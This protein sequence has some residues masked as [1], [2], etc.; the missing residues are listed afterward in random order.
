MA[1]GSLLS[2]H[3]KPELQAGTIIGD[4]LALLAVVCIGAT[5]GFKADESLGWRFAVMGHETQRC[6][7]VRKVP[8]RRAQYRC[9]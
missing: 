4:R 6:R 9:R 2:S 7:F 8:T 5:S 1:I 3:V